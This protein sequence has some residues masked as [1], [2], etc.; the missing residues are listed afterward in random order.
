M[1]FRGIVQPVLFRRVGWVR[2]VRGWKKG[3]VPDKGLHRTVPPTS[4]GTMG[5][6]Y[7]IRDFDGKFEHGLSL[8]DD[9]LLTFLT[10]FVHST[11]N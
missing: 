8:I 10:V 5:V 9:L 6:L 3:V 7:G 11:T 1:G 4:S 2:D